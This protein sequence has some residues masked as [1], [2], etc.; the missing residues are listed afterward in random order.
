M[1]PPNINDPFNL[2]RFI[3]AQK[4]VYETALGELQAG[5][6]QSHWMWFIFPQIAGLGASAMAQRYAITSSEEAH[7]YVHHPV[8][9]QRLRACTLAL[10]AHAERTAREIFGSPDDLKFRS[11]LTLFSAVTPDESVFDEA[12]ETFFDSVPD[13]LTTEKLE[14]ED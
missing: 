10:N 13:P 2:Q 8:L 4:D 5:R 1:P 7:A 3:D 9:G 11:S 14:S 12:L 6:K